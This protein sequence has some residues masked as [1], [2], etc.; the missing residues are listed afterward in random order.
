M[1]KP[2]TTTAQNRRERHKAESRAELLQAAHDLVKEEG[3]EGLT[4]R[5]LAKR[6]GYAPMSV[7]SYFADKHAILLAL[8]EDAF[9]TL[10]RRMEHDAPT[11]PLAA[12]R[13]ILEDYAAFALDNPNEYLTV[14]M[15]RSHMSPEERVAARTDE[16]ET[17]NPALRILFKCVQAC[18]D[19]GILKGDAHAIST[20]LWSCGHGAISLQITFPNYPFG[21]RK[22]FFHIAVDVT[23]A[24]LMAR[25]VEALAP[26]K[27][28]G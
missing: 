17:N 4:I 13:K 5:N 25:N 15:S 1:N 3:Y 26:P 9:E 12:L 16:D 23:L 11:E 21:D 22:K 18:I 20:L 2:M 8:A 19:A 24:G 10:A 14:S 6:V 28:R 27:E 7:Y